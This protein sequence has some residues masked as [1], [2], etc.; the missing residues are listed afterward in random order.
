MPSP[1]Q[2]TLDAIL[3]QNTTGLGDWSV[4]V[5][6]SEPRQDLDKAGKLAFV[7]DAIYNSSLRHKVVTDIPFKL[8]LVEHAFQRIESQNSILLSRDISSPNIA[9]KGQLAAR[10]VAITPT[11]SRPHQSEQPPHRENLIDPSSSPQRHPSPSSVQLK[12]P[13]WSWTKEA[14]SILITV[15][16][17]D[18]PPLE[19][20]HIHAA[21]LDLETRR[22]IL[23]VPRFYSLDINLGISDADITHSLSS[24]IVGGDVVRSTQLEQFLTLKRAREFDIDNAVAEWR[25]TQGVILV[26]V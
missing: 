25:T 1:S 17:P 24:A 10:S 21:A 7:V 12:M 19:R 9:F 18:L 2:T 16:V 22:L 23:H 6:I 20:S 3:Q 8:F 5:V 26:H 4:P 13:I 15:F 11:I 14:S